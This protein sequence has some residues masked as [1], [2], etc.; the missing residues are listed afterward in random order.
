MDRKEF[1]KI[2][3]AIRSI[4]NKNHTLYIGGENFSCRWNGES[5]TWYVNG[6]VWR[7]ICV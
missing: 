2:K 6:R 3:K 1:N 5:F 4:K 7:R